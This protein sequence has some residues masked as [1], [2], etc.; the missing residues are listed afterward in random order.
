MPTLK[1]L[2]ENKSQEDGVYTSNHHRGDITRFDNQV[3]DL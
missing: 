2:L 1:Y 3:L